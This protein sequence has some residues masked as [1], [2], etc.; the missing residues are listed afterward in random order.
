MDAKQAKDRWAA[1][2]PLPKDVTGQA[3]MEL[4]SLERLAQQLDTFDDWPEAEQ[5]RFRRL[6]QYAER[7]YPPI[8]SDGWRKD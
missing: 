1:L 8:G 6:L 5:H 2:L 3:A 4:A 7:I